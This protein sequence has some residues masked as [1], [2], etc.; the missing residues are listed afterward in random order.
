MPSLND[1]DLSESRVS[2]GPTLRAGCYLVRTRDSEYKRAASGGQNWIEQVTF[3]DTEGHGQIKESFNLFHSSSEA[4]RI[5]REQFKT[6]LTHGKH[7]NPDKPSSAPIDGLLLKII[8]KAD[9]TYQRDGQTFTSY[10]ISRYMSADNPMPTGPAEALQSS[11]K[12]NGGGQ[13]YGG[14]QQSHQRPLDDEI[15]F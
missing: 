6:M 3:E 7:P 2:N 1:L 12:V 5:G 9:G 14:L 8:V 4:Q 11:A 15:P 13:S 10:R